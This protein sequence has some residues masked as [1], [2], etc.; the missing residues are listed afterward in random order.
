MVSQTLSETNYFEEA[1]ECCYR[2]LG[3]SAEQAEDLFKHHV[4]VSPDQRTTYANVIQAMNEKVGRL[5]AHRSNKKISQEDTR[6]ALVFLA[7][8]KAQSEATKVT[9]VQAYKAKEAVGEKGEDK[10]MLYL[11]SI[12]KARA[13]DLLWCEM[14]I[15][16]HD[17]LAAIEKHGDRGAIS[18]LLNKV[19]PDTTRSQ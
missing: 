19:K 2:A 10:T 7:Q 8:V 1:T 3:I 16:K 11:D 9:M 6:K 15:D 13:Y 18:D 4:L 5:S 12:L 17:L 14:Q